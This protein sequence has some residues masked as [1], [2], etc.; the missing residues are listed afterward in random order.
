LPNIENIYYHKLPH[1]L[2]DC[3]AYEEIEYTNS[4]IKWDGKN[5]NEAGDIDMMYTKIAGEDALTD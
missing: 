4:V 3:P 5:K 2:Y 1:Y